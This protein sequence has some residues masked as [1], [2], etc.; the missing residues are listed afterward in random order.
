M[1]PFTTPHTRPDALTDALTDALFKPFCPHR[2]VIEK[3]DPGPLTVI[4]PST[5]T[6]AVETP[7]VA[8]QRPRTLPVVAAGEEQPRYLHRHAGR[9]YTTSPF[10]GVRGEPEAVTEAKQRDQTARARRR[11][12]QEQ[13]RAW[14][15]AAATIRRALSEFEHNGYVDA[16]VLAA[17]K[18]VERAA[19]RVDQRVG[20][21]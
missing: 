13:Q 20:L 9:N 3:N 19:R 16:A 5:P 21:S 1:A 7:P 11:W 18:G 10:L 14:G 17:T 4:V 15:K 8:E 12:Q 2:P 6:R